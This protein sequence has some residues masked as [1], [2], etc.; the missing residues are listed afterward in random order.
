MISVRETLT[1]P[2]CD[3]TALHVLDLVRQGTGRCPDSTGW[4]SVA[5]RCT[6]PW[7]RVLEDRARL[8]RNQADTFL[9]VGVGGSN[10]AARA[11]LEALPERCDRR[12]LYV[13][14]NISSWE[15]NRVLAQLQGHE[16]HIDVI[17]KNF[18]T[19]EP[20]IAFRR[21]RRYLTERY[22][23]RAAEHITVTGTEGS[24]LHD[25]CRR[26][27]YA[28]L[29][30]P[31]N[32]GGRF[33]AISEVGLLPMAAAGLNIR[34]VVAGAA[35]EE[36]RLMS[37]SAEENRALRYARARR[38][39]YE[40]G[41]R[42]ELLAF[43]EPRLQWFARWWAQL[44]GE[45]EGK[46]E[47]GM[48]P[49]WVSYTEDL[50]S[51]GQF[52]QEGSP[53][54]GETF[55]HLPQPEPSCQLPPDEVDDRFSYLDGMDFGA[56]N[57]A[58]YQATLA[59][60]SARLPCVELETDALSEKTFGRLFYFFEFACY[61]SAELLGVNPFDQPGVEA[62]KNRMFQ[63]LGKFRAPQHGNP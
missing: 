61:C 42:V 15:M 52:V 43:F 32:I 38:A 58:A 7:L 9:L 39:M 36:A 12:V 40:A 51:V 59:A 45:S 30:F 41:C 14:N 1:R 50:H 56:I 13:G 8:I 24:T 62:Y 60:H 21:L 37:E 3:E 22:G 18:E 26:H 63:A 10:N 34:D 33:T 27:G 19:L 48:Y 17:A 2:P 35:E 11:V 46:K 54:L 31:K 16:V 44:F 55:L 6:E 23:D 4:I 29:P 20:G 53:V 47:R 57:E 25:L 5:R 49:S 28:F